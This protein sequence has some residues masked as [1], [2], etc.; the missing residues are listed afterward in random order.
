VTGPDDLLVRLAQAVATTPLEHALSE[1]LC[2]ACRDLAGADSAA[3]TLAYAG[4][5][6]VTL[7][8]TD[9]LAARLE[10]LQDVLGEGPGHT[11]AATGRIEV[12]SLR[13][14]RTS[15]WPQFADTALGLVGRATVHAVP[16]RPDGEVLGVMTLYR[17]ERHGDAPLALPG[18]TLLRLAAA[19]AAALMRDP[20]AIA[21]EVEQGPWQSRARIHQATGMV[22]AQLGLAPDDAMAVLKAHAYAGEISLEDVASRVLDRALRFHPPTDRGR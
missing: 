16:M 10:D 7:F 15:P 5:H 3:L 1:R 17:E 9:A 21:E 11:A 2:L 22:V 4:S 12:C 8:T 6:R 19:T 18:D 13:D 14:G 20:D